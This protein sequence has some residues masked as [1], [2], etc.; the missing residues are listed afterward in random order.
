[1]KQ[2]ML[3]LAVAV[4]VLIAAACT[5]GRRADLVSERIEG[6]IVSL[7]PN[8]TETVFALGLGDRLVG[9]STACDYPPATQHIRKVGDFGAP[10]IELL[11]ALRPELVITTSLRDPEMA[12]AVEGS[13]AR[14]LTVRQGNLDEVPGTMQVIGE[15]AGVPERARRRAA[16]LRQRIAA[17][18]GEV[19]DAQRP[20]VFVEL[21]EKPLRTGGRGSFLDDLI[22]RA[23]GWN[24]AHD[25]D[26][27]WTTLSPE[28]VVVWD[29]EIVIVAH[30][31]EGD[32]RSALA[33][34]IG[35]GRITAV[36]SGAVIAD[37]DPALYLRPGP[38]LADGLEA[39]AAL[40][41]R[42]RRRRP[43]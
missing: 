10:K 31:I 20:R 40:F 23:G 9:V 18:T 12:K 11:Y 21:S 35:W 17:A 3:W 6:G 26:K 13:G 1:M 2:W 19:T 41:E 38:R 25:V 24:V 14:L 34:R 8:V 28:Q 36:R 39:F 5:L 16:E 30:P 22:H 43:E 33:R 37:L 42:Y 29:P 15:A 4:F 32:A 7:A 27:P